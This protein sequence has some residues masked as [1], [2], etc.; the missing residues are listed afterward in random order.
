MQYCH[1]EE[2]LVVDERTDEALTLTPYPNHNS[3]VKCI[4]CFTYHQVPAH[5]QPKIV[6][7]MILV[8]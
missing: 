4:Y 8:D 7:L 3:N 6:I 5:S 1:L 2:S